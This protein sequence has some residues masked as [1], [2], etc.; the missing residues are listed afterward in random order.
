MSTTI[1]ILAMLAALITF[2]VFIVQAIRQKPKK[3]WG[4]ACIISVVVFFIAFAFPTS[5][6]HQW[7]DATCTEPK[8]CTKCGETEGEPL[9]HTP[10]EWKLD[11]PSFVSATVWMRQYCAVCGERL[12]SELKALQALNENG[13]FL[14]SPNEFA[15]RL[16][17]MLKQINNC[18]LDAQLATLDDGTM[19]CGI[20]DSTGTIGILLYCDDD[21]VMEDSAQNNGNEI[22]SMI[23]TF[24]TD[25]MSKI[26][27]A[28]IGMILTSDPSLEMSDAASIAKATVL[29]MYANN[30]Y[31][32]KNG[33]KYLFG[34]LDGKYRFVVSVLE[35]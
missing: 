3:K 5:C 6:A 29:S 21:A 23:C 35:K 18:N 2:I 12:D 25:D 9:G 24:Q 10:G 13:A 19:G 4:I 20:I 16:S 8:T 14:F 31:Y 15:E 26:V 22:T 17:L 32:E 1:A 33:I 11:E 28:T 30:D 34:E 7:K 27:Q